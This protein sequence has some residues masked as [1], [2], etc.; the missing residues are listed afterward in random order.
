MNNEKNIIII[1][2]TSVNISK[3]NVKLNVSDKGLIKAIK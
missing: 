1:E 3:D 2:P